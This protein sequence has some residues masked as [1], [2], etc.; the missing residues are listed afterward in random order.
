MK[1]QKITLKAPL[2]RGASNSSIPTGQVKKLRLELE[3]S[4]VKNSI[5]FLAGSSEKKKQLTVKELGAALKREVIKIEADELQDKYI[6]ETE[7]NLS[8]FFQKAESKEWILF[9]DEADALF[10]KRTNVKDS[11]DKHANQE[12][13]YL[14]QRLEKYEGLVLISIQSEQTIKDGGYANRAHSII[15]LPEEEE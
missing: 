6:G 5:I 14:L 13:P 12:V 2:A 4:P 8:S 3:K 9:F 11:H 1:N 15:A 10:G 7:K